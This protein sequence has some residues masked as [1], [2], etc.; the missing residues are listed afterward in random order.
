MQTTCST[1]VRL[2]GASRGIGATKAGMDGET[3]HRP[4]AGDRDRS[5]VRIYGRSRRRTTSRKRGSANSGLKKKLDFTQ[6]IQSRR[7]S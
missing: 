4:R 7:D 6:G 3:A 1:S 2:A 5:D